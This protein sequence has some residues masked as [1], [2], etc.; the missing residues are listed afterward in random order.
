LTHK[1]EKE[2]GNQCGLFLAEWIADLVGNWCITQQVTLA[3]EQF[4]E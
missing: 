3:L 2:K 4:I 1:P